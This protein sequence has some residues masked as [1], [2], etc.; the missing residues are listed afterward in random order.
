MTER[1]KAMRL[2]ALAAVMLTTLGFLGEVPALSGVADLPMPL[3][4]GGI[5][6][7]GMIYMLA[8]VEP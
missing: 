5:I 6:T 8:K 3:M 2:L 4:A 7:A 1:V